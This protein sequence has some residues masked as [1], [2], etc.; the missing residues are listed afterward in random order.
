M[1]ERIFAAS[2]A[3]LYDAMYAGKDYA[4]EC[5]AIEGAIRRYGDG[6][7]CRSILDLGCGTGNHAIPL[8][9]R[10]YEVVGV[11][12]SEDMVAIA[13]R[14]AAETGV[15]AS[16][17]AGDMRDARLGRPFDVVVILFAALGYQIEDAGVASALGNARRHLRRGGLLVLDVWNAP[18]VFG[19]GAR[20]R[21][22]VVEGPDRQLIKASLRSL[23]PGGVHVNVRVRVWDIAGATVAAT[24]D[25]THRMRPFSQPELERFLGASGLAPRAFFAF[26]D[27]DA[28]VRDGTFDLGCV[29]AHSDPRSG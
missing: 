11:D 1:S 27:L 26:P 28:V 10:G 23:D 22:S 17:Q 21:V 24:A 4:R 13:R 12:L 25:E 15:G 20:D 29:A 8:A 9:R 2:Y 5:D 18:T 7:A 19:E 16:F 3:R 14:K 6:G